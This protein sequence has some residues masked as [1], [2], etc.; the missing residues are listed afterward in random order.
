MRRRARRPRRRRAGEQRR[1]GAMLVLAVWLGL[2]TL[3]YSNRRR[4][5]WAVAHRVVPALLLRLE[6]AAA[7]PRLS[8]LA[9]VSRPSWSR[10]RHAARDAQPLA[11][12]RCPVAVQRV[13]DGVGPVT[14]STSS[15][16]ACT[17]AGRPPAGPSRR[18]PRRSPR[19]RAFQR[20]D[21]GAHR[22][23][24]LRAGPS[25]RPCTARRPRGPRAGSGG[26]GRRPAR[27]GGHP[28]ARG[29]ARTGGRDRA[30]RPDVR[31]RRARAPARSGRRGTATTAEAPLVV[32]W[33]AARSAVE[34]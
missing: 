7:A 27:W 6:H 19:T 14:T 11:C 5:C 15:A 31:R 9:G 17:A 10:R 22:C 21:A 33:T 26:R 12:L 28:R 32:P 16:P 8:R 18:R 24:G 20:H 1:H 2:A 23:L 4:T 3:N 34:P 30:A 25:A 29:R 13:L